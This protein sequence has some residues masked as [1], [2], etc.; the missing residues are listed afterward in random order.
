MTG[1]WPLIFPLIVVVEPGTV[2]MD[3]GFKV[4]E[5]FDVIEGF[6]VAELDIVEPDIV[7]PVVMTY[8]EVMMV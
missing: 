8:R 2:D 5:G 7:V 4:I 6:E 3:A 1:D